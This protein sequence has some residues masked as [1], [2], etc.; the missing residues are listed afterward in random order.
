MGKHTIEFLYS[1]FKKYGY[2]LLTKD[3]SNAH[4]K[5]TYKDNNGYYYYQSYNGFDRN[6]ISL[7]FA[8]SNPYT[9]QNIKLWCK[10]N[11]KPYELLSEEFQGNDKNLE[12]KCFKCGEIFNAKWGN[13]L[14]G[15][16]CG[17]CAKNRKLSYD[18]VKY[19]IEV[20]SN[21]GCKLL[22]KEYFD[23][24]QK[25][26]LE[27]KCGSDFKVNFT[28]F[29]NG[30]KRQCNE[31]GYLMIADSRRNDYD[32]VK[33]FIEVK[34][35][36]GCKLLSKDYVD[37]TTPLYIQCKC[38]NDFYDTF[39]HFKVQNSSKSCEVCANKIKWDISKMQDWCNIN[40][41]GY[42]ILDVFR[43]ENTANSLYVKIKCPNPDHK[44]YVGSWN[45]F[46]SKKKLCKKCFADNHSRENH[47]NW[48]GGITALLFYL[49]GI[50]KQWK[51][52]SMKEC[53]YKCVITGKP[54]AN[55]HHLYSF[56][57]IVQDTLAELNLPVH[58]TIAEYSEDELKQ[59]SDKFIEIHYRYPLG[60][61]LSKEIH[62]LFHKEYGKNNTPE[63]FEEFKQR[64]YYGE[65]N[66]AI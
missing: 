1:E 2:E 66:I 54:F 4:E 46:Y 31:C 15:K 51:Q 3:Y 25:L 47:H 26:Q 65:F 42:K 41:I 60:V 63:Q 23:S 6:K 38:G 20:E 10:L 59:I 24:Y 17:K 52:D 5:L 21:S 14:Q 44:P 61:C 12:W 36:S 29:K 50:L 62:N 28:E 35:K 49:R 53:N 37:N 43:K 40:A 16:G 11:D 27:C 22:S 39:A 48:K 19:F 34:S 64:Y 45:N 57:Q 33:N 13:I 56:S 30:N 55:I 8:K 7:P 9:I 32:Y 58:S 18:E